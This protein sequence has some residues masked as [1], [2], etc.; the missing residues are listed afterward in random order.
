MG[1]ATKAG[2]VV[3]GEFMTDKSVK[4]GRAKLVIIASDASDNTKKKFQNMCD[5][6]Q[7]PIFV[8]SNKITLGNAIGKEYRASLCVTDIGLAKEIIKHLE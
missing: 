7:V 4:E 8:Y 5:Y 2:K 6:Y 1:L 3:S